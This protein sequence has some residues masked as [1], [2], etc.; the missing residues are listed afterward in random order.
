MLEYEVLRRHSMR[1]SKLDIAQMGKTFEGE[2]ELCC[3]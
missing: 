1:I 3:F 2:S